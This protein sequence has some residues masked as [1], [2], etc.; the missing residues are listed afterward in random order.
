LQ[1]ATSN[2]PPSTATEPCLSKGLSNC[3][4]AVR[5]HCF[6]APSKTSL[7]SKAD[8]FDRVASLRPRSTAVPSSP[9]PKGAPSPRS[10]EPPRA[11]QRHRLRDVVAR[12]P[13]SATG[14]AMAS[15][16]SR[17]PING[18]TTRVLPSRIKAEM[19]GGCERL[20]L[21]CLGEPAVG[22]S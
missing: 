13:E 10:M 16:I 20:L 15:Q 19:S 22:V 5:L 4:V 9:G 17:T 21:A 2:T 14:T 18:V 3:R 11:A 6:Q 1:N 7:R 8:Q 12:T